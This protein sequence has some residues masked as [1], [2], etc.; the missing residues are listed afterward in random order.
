M[1]QKEYDIRKKQKLNELESKIQIWEF[2]A[3]EA[4]EKVEYYDNLV[5]QEIE[6]SKRSEE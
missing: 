5:K 1:P 6:G 2:R 3:K 4:D